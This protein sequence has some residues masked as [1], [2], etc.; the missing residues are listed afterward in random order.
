M[1]TVTVVGRAAGQ[2]LAEKELLAESVTRA[3]YDEMP[4]LTARYG[5]VGR[6]KCL[7]DLRFTIEHLIPAVDLGQPEM[8]ASYVQWL[9]DLLRARHVS[10]REVIRSL[11]LLE[12]IV[13][14]RFAGDQAET[15][16]HCIR[17]GLERLPD[18]EPQR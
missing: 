4:G 12:G 18:G 6:E 16:A 1:D 9:D 10:T 11:E 2:L 13:R 17:A 8:F 7:Q 15:I 14:E 5:P 3:L